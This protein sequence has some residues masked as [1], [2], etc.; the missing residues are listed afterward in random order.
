MGSSGGQS[1]NEDVP[2]FELP[3]APITSVGELQHFFLPGQRPFSIGN[4]WGAGVQVN[5]QDALGL[6]D[7]FFFSGLPA[8][9]SPTSTGVTLVPPNSLLRVVARNGATG[10]PV[11]ASDLQ[12]LTDGRSSKYFLQSGAFNLNSVNPAAW[13]AVL[14]GVRF[15]APS[16]FTY[17]D[18]DPS[19]GTADD[20]ATAFVQS[21]D[22]QFFRFSQSAQ[23]TYKAEPGN[24]GGAAATELFRQGMRTLPPAQITALA[25]TI[26]DAISAHQTASG[27]FRSLAEFL[28]PIAGGPSLLEQAI[29]DANIN[30][31]IGEFS[32]QWLTQGDIM[33]ALAPVLFPRSDTFVIRTYGDVV[34]PATSTTA[35]PVV[36]GRAWAEAVVQRFPDYFDPSDPPETQPGDF[37]TPSDPN[38]PTST[39]S[40][41]HQLN[42]LYGRRFKIVSFRWLTRNDL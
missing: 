25:K 18:S 29:A 37:A 21:N 24:S 30:A 2:I 38:D 20:S 17:L 11:A 42:Q 10:A 14:R 34:N 40:T 28:G 23:E 26:A 39:P 3:R 35:A 31:T 27:P 1:Y 5:G 32:S 36:E 33:T 16:S 15:P 22:A 41:A 9:L 7:Q 12:A 19:T 8:P 4:S 13:A 6:F